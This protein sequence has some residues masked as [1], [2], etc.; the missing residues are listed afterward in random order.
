M[1]YLVHSAEHTQMMANLEK[2][3]YQWQAFLEDAS[4]MRQQAA[5]QFC[6]SLAV[7]AHADGGVGSVNVMLN[8]GRPALDLLPKVQAE[9]SRG[10]RR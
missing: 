8:A 7:M 6:G 3:N 10:L 5:L 9:A 1:I 2:L 4:K